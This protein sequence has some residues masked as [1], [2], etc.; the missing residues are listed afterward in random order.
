MSTKCDSRWLS[1]QSKTPTILAR[2][3]KWLKS[4]RWINGRTLYRRVAGTHASRSASHQD[5]QRLTPAEERAIVKW[6]HD[7]DDRGFPP[8]LDMVKD[9]ALHLEEHRTG[10]QPTPIGKHW[11]SRFLNRNHDLASKLSTQLERQRAYSNDP[12][13]LQDYF[14]KLCRLIRLHG[15]QAFQIFNMDEKGFLMGLVAKAKVPCRRG[16][17][18]PRVTHDGKRELVTVVESISGAGYALTPF[19]INKGAGH[20]LGWYR[21]LTTKQKKWHFSY[22]PR[23]WIDDYLALKWLEEVFDPQSAELVG[24]PNLPRLLVFDGHGSHITYEFVEYCIQHNILLLCLPSHSTH[25]LQPLDVGLFGPYQHFYRLEVD[26]YMR[27]GQNRQGIKKATFIPFLAEARE[28]TFLR[29]TIQQA[30]AATGI[31]PLNPRRVLGKVAPSSPKRRDTFG[32]VKQLRTSRDIRHQVQVGEALLSKTFQKINLDGYEKQA[33]DQ[34]RNIMR[35]LGHQL[36]EEIAEKEIFRETNRRLQGTKE[37]YNITDRRRLAVAR[38]LDGDELTR[39]RDARLEKDRQRAEKR[40]KKTAGGQP[41]IRATR[42]GTRAS[43]G[44]RQSLPA[45]E[46]P[47]QLV[48]E[49]VIRGTPMVAFLDSEVDEEESKEEISDGEWNGSTTSP[50]KT[51][52]RTRNF[53]LSPRAKKRLVPDRPLHMALCSRNRSQALD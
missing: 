7:Q 37:I 5:Q 33:L 40:A 47:P 3:P 38:F 53:L 24:N 14:N 52:P 23:G 43:L 48:Q 15:L 21:N 26:K 27:S 10:Q 45:P 50:A 34:V 16:R 8:H 4:L 18:N 39:L 28:Q 6:C 25:L 42:R 11:I 9:M 22:S 20:Y 51:T 31:C 1:R 2:Y 30:F 29:S 13:L 35:D 41:K 46:T 19:V 12:R 49:V 44:Q 36:E 32:I 17:R